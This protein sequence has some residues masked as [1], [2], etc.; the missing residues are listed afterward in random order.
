M[1]RV[2]CIIF[3]LS[4]L[5]TVPGMAAGGEEEQILDRFLSDAGADT[6]QKWVDGPLSDDPDGGVWYILTLLGMGEK[7]DYSAYRKALEKYAEKLTTSDGVK[8]LRI[9][10]TLTALGSKSDFPARTAA[11]SIG[12]QGQMSYVF[13]LHLLTNGVKCDAWTGETLSR[14]IV[15]RQLPD[16]G[17]A[18]MGEKGDVDVTAMTLTALAPYREDNAVGESIEKALTFLSEAQLPGGGYYG[19]SGENPESAAQVLCALSALGIDGDPRFLKDGGSVRSAL[20]AFLTEAGDVMHSADDSTPDE[21]AAIQTLYALAAYGRMRE[22][23]DPFFV[24]DPLPE[25]EK[26]GLSLRGWLYI[27]DG[28]LFL[29]L[30]LVSFLRGKRK[31][32]TYL[33]YFILALLIA[34][35]VRFVRI[36]SA[37]D[38]YAAPEETG[39]MPTYLT[40]RCDTV[41]GEAEHIPADGVILPETELLLPEG[42]S[43]YDQ[44]VLAARKYSIQT[45]NDGSDLSPYIIGIGNIYAFDFGDLSGWMFRVNGGYGDTGCGSVILSPGDRVEWVYTR[46]LGKDVE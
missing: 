37:S 38:Y 6:L 20:L 5:L 11:D 29:V 41:A 24:F 36:E 4:L 23:K 42:A 16:G 25:A 32:K 39:T 46:E 10:L 9:A 2:I 43:A 17:W 13:G 26:T 27:G 18:V 22:G 28:A 40:I 33:L 35:G 1:K 14:R 31:I 45:E 34:L 7:C 21:M 44:L 15:S 30:C 3:A 8:R 12:T 19:L